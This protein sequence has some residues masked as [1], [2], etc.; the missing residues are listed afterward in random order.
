MLFL[1]QFHWGQSKMLRRA[2]WSPGGLNLS[3]LCE[4]PMAQISTARW[5][6]T[7]GVPWHKGMRCIWSFLCHT[8]S[9]SLSRFAFIF[10]PEESFVLSRS[11]NGTADA[12]VSVD[13]PNRASMATLRNFFPLVGGL[14]SPRCV[15]AVPWLTHSAAVSF[16][17][18]WKCAQGIT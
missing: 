10:L 12:E 9:R 17:N 7:M 11:L 15:D 1:T 16:R 2:M 14:R 5:R 6:A 13:T 4:G 8:R 3:V 18:W